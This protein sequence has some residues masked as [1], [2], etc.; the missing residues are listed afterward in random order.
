MGHKARCTKALAG[1]VEAIN[2]I[3]IYIY[4]V[5]IVKGAP[6]PN[7][8]GFTSHIVTIK[9]VLQLASHNEPSGSGWMMHRCGRGGRFGLLVVDGR[10]LAAAGVL[11]ARLEL[12]FLNSKEMLKERRFGEMISRT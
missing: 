7:L 5:T 6:Y 3:S 9:K 1:A 2:T 10:F 11:R 4:I 8:W 12:A